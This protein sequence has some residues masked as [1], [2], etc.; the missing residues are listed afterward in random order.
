[1]ASRGVNKVILVGNLGGTRKYA[2]CRVVAQLPTL[3]WL[4][5]N[6]A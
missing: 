4:L 6:L 1:M 2:T 5:P 3:R